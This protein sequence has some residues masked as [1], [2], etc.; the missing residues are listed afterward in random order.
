MMRR[1]TSDYQAATFI[2]RLWRED[3]TPPA[4]ANAWRGTAVHVQSGYE[5][6]IV[7]FEDLI[8]FIHAWLEA[9][10]PDTPPLE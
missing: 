7:G 1:S 2:V 6:G 10:K 9:G 8:G 3:Q 4:D 5:R